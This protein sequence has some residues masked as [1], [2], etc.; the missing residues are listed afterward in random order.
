MFPRSFGFKIKWSGTAIP[1][2]AAEKM[3]L[4]TDKKK[5][6]VD[7]KK[8]EI[9][10][11]LNLEAEQFNQVF[12]QLVSIGRLITDFHREERRGEKRRD[13]S[14]CEGCVGAVKRVLGKMQVGRG[15][16]IRSSKD[17]ELASFWNN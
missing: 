14:Q 11:L 3:W 12:D 4:M 13:M 16:S 9:Q 7:D 10:K 6:L 17:G 2:L 1:I 5:E 15:E 8:L